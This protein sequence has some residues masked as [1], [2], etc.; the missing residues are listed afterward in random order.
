MRG[1][2]LLGAE[3][4][5]LMVATWFSIRSC[6]FRRHSQVLY[7]CTCSTVGFYFEFWCDAGGIGSISSGMMWGCVLG[8]PYW[9][10]SWLEGYVALWVHP[11]RWHRGHFWSCF[12]VSHP[13]RCCGVLLLLCHCNLWWCHLFPGGLVEYFRELL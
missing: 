2:V 7:L 5:V 9:C 13:Q 1:P 10:L 3:F 4:G 12:W 8:W 6:P 11:M